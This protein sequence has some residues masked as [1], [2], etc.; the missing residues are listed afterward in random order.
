[1]NPVITEDIREIKLLFAPDHDKWDG[2]APETLPVTL[3]GREIVRAI[4]Y[5]YN[6]SFCIPVKLAEEMKRDGGQFRFVYG[7]P[8]SGESYGPKPGS[9]LN[10]IQIE[11]TP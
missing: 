4:Y 2:T 10:R 5:D 9:T 6:Y 8:L 11:K 1:M 3:G 7:H